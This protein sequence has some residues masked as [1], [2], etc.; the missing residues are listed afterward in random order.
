MR[1]YMGFR[2]AGTCYV[3]QWDAAMPERPV[4]LTS[5]TDLKTYAPA[6]PDWGYAGSGP[7]Q[8]ALDL[9]AD[10]LGDPDRSLAAHVAPTRAWVSTLP[11]HCWSIDCA[12]AGGPDRKVRTGS[13]EERE[14][15]SW[16]MNAAGV[17]GNTV[18]A[19]TSESSCL[20]L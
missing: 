12:S 4:R 7:A 1:I 3:Y 18:S 17:R 20:T 19:W 8:L 11:R 15:K 13:P 5:R 6:S 9:A 2:I 16:R 14:G 10:A